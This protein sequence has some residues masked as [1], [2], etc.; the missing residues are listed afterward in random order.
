MLK[1]IPI[2]QN[3]LLSGVPMDS[4]HLLSTAAHSSDVSIWQ[5]SMWLP[6]A[7][8]GG[9]GVV[10]DGVVDEAGNVPLFPHI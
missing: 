2:M 7:E 4:E 1:S 5:P 10:L 3:R 9:T 6:G 8:V